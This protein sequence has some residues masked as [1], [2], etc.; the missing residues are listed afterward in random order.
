MRL[1]M[2]VLLKVEP[3]MKMR[4]RLEGFEVNGG[5]WSGGCDSCEER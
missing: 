5:M 4:Q 3:V 2:I 1:G